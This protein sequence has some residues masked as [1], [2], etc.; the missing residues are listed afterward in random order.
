MPSFDVFERLN[1]SKAP[2]SKEGADYF[3][4]PFQNLDYWLGG[5][6]Q[7]LLLNQ[8]DFDYSLRVL[9][10]WDARIKNGFIKKS[11][12]RNGGRYALL[13]YHSFME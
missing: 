11:F 8:I 10:G 2:A 6:L 9:K 5:F 12:I 1:I 13:K 3:D 7:V 4:A